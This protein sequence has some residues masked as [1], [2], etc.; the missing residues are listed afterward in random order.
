MKILI[1][2][3]EGNL[4]DEHSIDMDASRVGSGFIKGWIDYLRGDTSS[5][6]M[7]SHSKKWR[8]VTPE[9]VRQRKLDG[10]RQQP[11]SI[12]VDAINSGLLVKNFREMSERDFQKFIDECQGWRLRRYHIAYS[13]Q[14][15]EGYLNIFIP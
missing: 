1:C 11:V 4:L 10:V 7:I 2:D 5:L 14:D 13:V 12:N 15:L 8:T 6:R 9:E 3:D